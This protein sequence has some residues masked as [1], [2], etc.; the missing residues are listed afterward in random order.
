M[1]RCT[2]FKT[3]HIAI[4]WDP[5]GPRTEECTVESQLAVVRTEQRSKTSYGLTGAVVVNQ[6]QVSE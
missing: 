3:A 1:P 6:A 5:H 2:L 4:L